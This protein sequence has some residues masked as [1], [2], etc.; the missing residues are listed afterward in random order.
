MNP[1]KKYTKLSLFFLADLQ[2]HLSNMKIY[3]FCLPSYSLIRKKTILFAL[4]INM[5][6]LTS[7]LMVWMVGQSTPSANLL[8][9]QRKWGCP[10]RLWSPHTWR[11]SKA[12]WI[13]SCATCSRWLCLS[14]D[15]GKMDLWRPLQPQPF[16]Q[17]RKT[18]ELFLRDTTNKKWSKEGQSC[19]TL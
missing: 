12:T 13:W 16:C 1:K 3:T 5:T 9:T 2:Q 15:L 8:M 17:P 6:C 11:Y 18:G 14:R 10:E 7:W 4:L 19:H